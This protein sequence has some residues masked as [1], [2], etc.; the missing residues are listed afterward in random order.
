MDLFYKIKRLPLNLKKTIKKFLIIKYTHISSFL[1]SNFG[2]IRYLYFERQ[3]KKYNNK[4]FKIKKNNI[5]I[6]YEDSEKRSMPHHE[7]RVVP[8]WQKD[9]VWPR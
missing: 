3:I 9:I 5:A 7:Q 2:F 8:P 4:N 6:I 1:I